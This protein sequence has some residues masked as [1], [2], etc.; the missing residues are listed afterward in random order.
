MLPRFGPYFTEQ[1]ATP[2]G[3]AINYSGAECDE[4]RRY[5][6]DNALMW[7]RDYRLDGLRLDAVHAII[8]ASATHLLEELS[9]DVGALSA[10]L[11]R[12]LSIVAESDLNDPRIVTARDASGYGVD[13]QWSDDFHH[14]LHAVLTGERAGYYADFGSLADVAK[15][16]RHGF[17]YTGEYSGHRRRRHGRSL[18]PAAPSTRLLGYAQNHDQIGNRAAGQR[19][20]ALVSP[21]LLKVAAALVMTSPFTPMLFMGEE[22][23]ASTP[24]QYF[25]DHQDPA[26][27]EAVRTG[28]RAEFGAFGWRPQDVPDPQDPATVRRSTLDWAELERAPHA[29]LFGWHRDLVALRKRVAD[30]TDVRLDRVQVRF[31]ETARW[32]AVRRGSVEVVANLSA[33]SRDVDVDATEVLLASASTRL[34]D[35]RLTLAPESV[36]VVA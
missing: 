11:G 13:A 21:G 33:S 15:A 1:F 10:Q 36:A 12:P 34:R 28:R 8:D 7:L 6:I 20:A 23:G 16:L 14:A 17:V 35:G 25:T 4:V 2:W 9:T 26:L 24:W 32:L 31:D 27:A 30:L 19:L 5:A 18:P 29:E 3:K 22:W